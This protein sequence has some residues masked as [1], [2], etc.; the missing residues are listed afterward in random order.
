MTIYRESHMIG[1]FLSCI[2]FFKYSKRR[3]SLKYL[4]KF[5]LSGTSFLAHYLI[6]KTNV[7]QLACL[8]HRSHHS[9]RRWCT[10]QIRKQEQHFLIVTFLKYLQRNSGKTQISF[11]ADFFI[12]KTSVCYLARLAHSSHYSGRWWCTF[13]IREAK[14]SATFCKL[15]LFLKYLCRN[16]PRS[17]LW[18]LQQ[19]NFSKRNHVFINMKWRFGGSKRHW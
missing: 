14:P 17:L 3:N 9:G 13:E 5:R 8:A 6:L 11:L 10:F 16:L 19:A 15:S 7:C 12:L 4:V 2:S 1:L 18:S